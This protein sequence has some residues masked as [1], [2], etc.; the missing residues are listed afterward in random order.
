MRLLHYSDNPIGALYSFEQPSH[1]LAWSGGRKPS[2]LWVSVE[3]PDD[4][5]S[6]CEAEGFRDCDSQ[7]TTEVILAPEHGVLIID[8]LEAL[9][10]FHEESRMKGG[11]SA[12]RE[13]IDWP[14]VAER[15]QGIIIAPYRWEQRLDAPCDGW[16]YSWDCA[17]GCI[18]DASAIA[19]LRQV[20]EGRPRAET[21]EPGA[22][23]VASLPAG[24]MDP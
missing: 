16:Y 17:S 20:S 14:R 1:D 2:G 12:A 23:V 5:R 4:W 21:S 9:L 13:V 19:G 7:V 6:W 24:G 8:T 18:W 11:Y 15:H 10:A 22:V 3:G